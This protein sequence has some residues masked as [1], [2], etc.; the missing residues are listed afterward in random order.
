MSIELRIA[1][2]LWLVAMIVG[3]FA[4][5]YLMGRLRGLRPSMRDMDRIR[6]RN[7]DEH[8]KGLPDGE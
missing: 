3:S 2:V 6:Q 4:W 5:G 1:A 7:D 8:G